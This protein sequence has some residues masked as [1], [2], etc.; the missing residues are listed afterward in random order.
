[1][2]FGMIKEQQI[3]SPI[4]HMGSLRPSSNR[5]N[6]LK[7]VAPLMLTS[8]VDAFAV[9]VIYLLASTQQA[10]SELKTDKNISL[11]TASHSQ[12]L[13]P[14]V[15]LKVS[16]QQYI[17]NDTPIALNQLAQYLTALNTDLKTK[18]DTRHGNLI[19]QADKNADFS[20]LSPVLVVAAQTGFE[21]V[22]FA[23]IGE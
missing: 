14:G 3:M 19:I 17:I 10:G 15:N 18:N 1:M 4:E 16:G 5:S 13:Q 12:A 21:N 7:V 22:R 9:I 20:G 2:K 11:P 8:L 23:V 6:M